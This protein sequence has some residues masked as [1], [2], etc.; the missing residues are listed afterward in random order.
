[1][2]RGEKTKQAAGF[3][4]SYITN[5]YLL[6]TAELLIFYQFNTHFKILMIYLVN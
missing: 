1:M 4:S 5:I 3:V 2:S 6:T